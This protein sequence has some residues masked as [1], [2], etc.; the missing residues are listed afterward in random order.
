M[1]FKCFGYRISV[2][3]ITR[4][5][6]ELEPKFN[7]ES[8]LFELNRLHKDELF[9]EKFGRRCAPIKSKF[10]DKY[11]HLAYIRYQETTRDIMQRLSDDKL[12]SFLREIR[13]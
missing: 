5:S 1:K 12:I 10:I 13:S 8:F 9:R 4:K 2:K 7:R 11:P 3:K 6:Y